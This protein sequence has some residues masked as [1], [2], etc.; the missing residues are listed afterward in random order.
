MKLALSLLALF[1]LAAAP[2]A[3]DPPPPG[4]PQPVPIPIRF[5]PGT[6]GG[7][8]SGAVIRADRDIYS[9]G[10]QA[11][12]KMTVTI[13]AQEDN[14]VFQVYPPDAAPYRDADDMVGITGTPLPG[15]EGDTKHWTGPMPA[16]GTYLIKVGSTRGNATYE[17]SV[18]LE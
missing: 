2:A 7:K 8:A 10:A 13:K 15:A 17:L 1:L 9:V 6:N 3:A 16:T 4:T 18:S 11:G 12:Q 5:T 14:A